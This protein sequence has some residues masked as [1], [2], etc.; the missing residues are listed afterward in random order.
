MSAIEQY[1]PYLTKYQNNII[2]RLK[3]IDLFLK[4]KPSPYTKKDTLALLKISNEELEEL[5][6]KNNIS[7]ITSES[8]MV[9]MKN[10]SDEL[11]RVFKRELERGLTNY[12]SPEQVSYIYNIDIDI[13]LNAYAQM[14]VTKLHHGLLETLFSNIYI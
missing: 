3:E 2:P 8:F 10:G 11:C 14:G 4:T 7:K 13:I 6:K 9:I 12:Y 1:K 5:M